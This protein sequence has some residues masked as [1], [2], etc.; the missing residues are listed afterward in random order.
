[1]L[2]YGRTVYYLI[3]QPALLMYRVCTDSHV[4]VQCLLDKIY[5]D[6]QKYSKEEVNTCHNL[7]KYICLAKSTTR[8]NKRY[9][10]YVPCTYTRTYSHTSYY[11][12]SVSWYLLC[13]SVEWISLETT[14]TGLHWLLPY[15]CFFKCRSC[16]QSVQV[17]SKTRVV[18]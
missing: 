12:N 11:C 6:V 5:V 8:N 10:P 2:Y 16:F 9:F 14:A 15:K 3:Q 1:M 4:Y 17:V 18:F 13:W 7:Q